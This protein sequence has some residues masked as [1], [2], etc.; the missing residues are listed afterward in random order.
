MH[1]LVSPKVFYQTSYTGPYAAARP[2]G[3]GGAAARREQAA[4]ELGR[5]VSNSHE[6]L[7]AAIVEWLRLRQAEIAHAI[8]IRIRAAV[9]SP[10]S[11]Q[12]D[13]DEAGLHAAIG[14]IVSYRLDAIEAGDGYSAPI[15]P[16]A[17]VQTRLAARAGVGLGTVQRRYIAGHRVFGEFVTQAVEQSGLAHNEQ[18]V[19]QLRRAQESLLEHVIAEIEQEY[20]RE[21]HLMAGSLDRHREEIVR[22]LLAG[23][24][25]EPTKL[26]ELHY[27]IR[28]AWHL[29]MVVT[30]ARMEGVI[31]ALKARLGRDLLVVPQDGGVAWMWSAARRKP[32]DAESE[33]MLSPHLHP[34][35]FVTIGEP[36][37]GID[38]WRQT[39]R[40][41]QSALL[42][43][44]DERQG[45]VRYADCHF[46]VAA[47]QI[48]TLAQHL[49]QK[50]LIPLR[51]E[52]DGGAMLRKTLR[53]W[54]DTEG[55]ASSAA[56]ILKV[57]RHTVENHV[58]IVEKLTGR[59]LRRSCLTELDV[60]LRL[61]ES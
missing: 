44:L 45:V 55:Y 17:A 50:Y 58:R 42:V 36:G 27:D 53:A 46:L 48:D 43:A 52:R 4:H 49:R 34:G 13:A 33:R 31:A 54:V 9:P 37:A 23:E 38:G 12:G 3:G 6:L 57:D 18:L 7:F 56:K 32:T 60:V 61:E 8:Y 16:S 15:P 14:A 11:G 24:R 5:N 26:A 25:I 2:T 22:R 19:N 29:G 47:R 30:G 35:T 39:H 10:V 28:A 1:R 41:A 51:S 21:L 40:E 20:N 59:P